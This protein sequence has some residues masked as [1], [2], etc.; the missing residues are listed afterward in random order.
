MP[1][2][3]QGGRGG[4]RDVTHINRTDPGAPDSREES[5][6]ADDCFPERE[7]PLHEEVRTKE[8]V[9]HRRFAYL[10][11]NRGVITQKPYWRIR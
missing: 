3:D 6:L 11:L 9:R 8:G 10:L 2:L 4:R 1:F 7:Q 5:A